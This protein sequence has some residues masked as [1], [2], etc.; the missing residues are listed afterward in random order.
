[1]VLCRYQIYIINKKEISLFKVNSSGT[2]LVVQWLRLHASNAGGDGLIPGWGI[3][4][5][6]A[7]WPK[8]NK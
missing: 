3:K 6:H 2:S 7:M 1:M 8:I 4:I 5:P